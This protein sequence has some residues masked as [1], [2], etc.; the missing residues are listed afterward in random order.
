MSEKL[1]SGSKIQA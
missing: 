1:L